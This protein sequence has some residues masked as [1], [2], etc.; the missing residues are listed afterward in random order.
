MNMPH[1]NQILIQNE[2]DNMLVIQSEDEETIKHWFNIIRAAVVRDGPSVHHGYAS[3]RRSRIASGKRPQSGP[4]NSLA[5]FTSTLGRMIGRR[6][7][8]PF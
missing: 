5:S 1:S 4:P 2:A 6:P 7:S 3:R 8:Q